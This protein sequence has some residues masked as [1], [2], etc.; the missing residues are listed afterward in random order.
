MYIL[1]LSISGIC[2]Y[3]WHTAVDQTIKVE[4][5][6]R[7]LILFSQDSYRLV[8]QLSRIAHSHSA[9]GCLF[10]LR[11]PCSQLKINPVCK[12]SRTILS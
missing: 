9:N 3:T 11:L 5:E 12:S 1:H 2:R 8:T 7:A 10:S 6:G 4:K